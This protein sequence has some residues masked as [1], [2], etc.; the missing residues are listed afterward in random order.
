MSEKNIIDTAINNLLQDRK[1]Y[2]Y[3][4]K[5]ANWMSKL[6]LY[7]CLY[8]AQQHGK[9]VDISILENKTEVN[10]H[11]NCQCEYVPMRTKTAGTATE[12]GM[13]GADAY[14]VRFG[15]LPDY[16][17]NKQAAQQ[18]GWQTTSK[19]LSS[20]LPGKMIGGDVYVNDD[21]KLPTSSGRIWYEADINYVSGKRNR[22]RIVYSNDGLIF[23]TYDHY[24]TFYEITR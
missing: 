8:C 22:Q 13:D 15:R 3:S 19:K 10:A 2:G 16:Y 21:F 9:I 20:V 17:V 24:Q 11:E 6:T 18:A 5:W 4:I 1:I 7:T 14:I 12:L 23:A